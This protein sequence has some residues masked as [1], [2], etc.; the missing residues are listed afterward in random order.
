MGYWPKKKTPKGAIRNYKRFIHEKGKTVKHSRKRVSL[1]Q[2]EKRFTSEKE[3][4]EL[5]LRRLHAL[6]KQRFGFFPFSQYFD[7]WLADVELVLNEFQSDLNIG[8][9]DQF[10]KECSETLANIKRQLE[11]IRLKEASVNQEIKNFTDNKNSLEMVYNEYL[12]KS[13]E[14]RAEKI[15]GLKRLYSRVEALRKEEERVIRS[16]AGFFRSISQKEKEQKEA[17]LA[18][19]MGDKERQ[20]ELA[21]LDL[22]TTQKQLRESYEAKREPLFE[23]QKL[24]RR[25]I[26]NFEEDDSLEERWFACET[27]IDALNNYLQRKAARQSKTPDR[28]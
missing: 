23:K 10:V 26:D 4:T 25:R 11:E 1:I 2:K 12:A 19:K 3:V 27:L 24:Y 20:A 16:K 15:R 5:T 17:E 28:A 13:R 14:V 18:Q 9:D 6:G 7:P 21:M 8:V 22:K